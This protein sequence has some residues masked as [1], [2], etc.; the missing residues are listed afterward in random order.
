MENLTAED[1]VVFLVSGGGSA[2]FECPLIPAEELSH[3]T[4]AMLA[5]G[6]DIVEMNTVRKRLSAVKG[7]GS[8]SCA[9]RPGCSPSSCPTFWGTPWT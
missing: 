1:M 2:L 4:Q 9:P 7:G 8:P 6:A 5:C 3:L